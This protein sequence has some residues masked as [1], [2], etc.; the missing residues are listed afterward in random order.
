MPQ[1]AFVLYLQHR[2]EFR[3]P[4]YEEVDPKAFEKIVYEDWKNMHHKRREKWLS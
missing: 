1:N 4:D 2:Q 3:E